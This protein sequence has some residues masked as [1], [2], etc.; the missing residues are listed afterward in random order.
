MLDEAAKLRKTLERREKVT[1]RILAQI[2]HMEKRS[3]L[4]TV[5]SYISVSAAERIATEIE[6]VR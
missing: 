4:H 3:L 5:L 1:Q 6:K 2:G